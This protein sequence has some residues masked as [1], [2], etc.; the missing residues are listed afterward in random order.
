[1]APQQLS[2]NSFDFFVVIILTPSLFLTK[3]MCLQG[4]THRLN[5]L[6]MVELNNFLEF[7]FFGGWEVG[8]DDG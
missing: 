4:F 1:M 8:G 6:G 7:F 2:N 5:T 3:S